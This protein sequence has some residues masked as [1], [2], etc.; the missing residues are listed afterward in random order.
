M[1]HG[2]MNPKE[3]IAEQKQKDQSTVKN[4]T[5]LVKVLYAQ[6]KGVEFTKN[7]IPLKNIGIGL[8]GN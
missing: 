2:E 5:G 3:H 7:L 8:Q 1:R 6:Y 4:L